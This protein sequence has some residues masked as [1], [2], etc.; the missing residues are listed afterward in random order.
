MKQYKTRIESAE[1]KNEENL[2]TR[3][4]V[5]YKYQRNTLSYIS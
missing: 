5:K 3:D 1:R 2:R 4:K